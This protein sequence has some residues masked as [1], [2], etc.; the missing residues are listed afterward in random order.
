MSAATAEIL[1]EAASVR[2]N[3]LVAP[4]GE[5]WRVHRLSSDGLGPDEAVI[6]R[7]RD[8]ALAYA[9]ATAA[10]ECYLASRERRED[11]AELFEIWR[12]LDDAYETLALERGDCAAEADS[13][14]IAAR[15]LPTR[16]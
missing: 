6:H 7:R 16:H 8:V 5:G 14:D 1:H 4:D 3:Y 9:D 2:A 15:P 12:R 11:S 13:W 10:L